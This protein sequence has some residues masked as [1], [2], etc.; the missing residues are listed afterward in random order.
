MEKAEKVREN[1]LR[2]KLDRM[3]FALRKSH[4]KD[5][6]AVDFGC[7]AIVNQRNVSVFGTGNEGW[8]RA[9]LDDVEEWIADQ[10]KPA[11]RKAGAK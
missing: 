3:G 1:L 6:D 5:P 2:R 7:Y 10:T 4:R 11:G 9:T 8:Y